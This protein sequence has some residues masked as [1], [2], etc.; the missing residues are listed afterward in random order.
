MK[1]PVDLL[2]NGGIGTYIKANTES[3]SEVNDKTNDAVRVNA[4]ELRCRV[5]AEGGNLGLTQL[6]RIEYAKKGGAINTDAIDN[7]GGVNCSDNE[8][9][10]KILLNKVVESSTITESERNEILANIQNDVA[11]LVLKNNYAQCRAISFASSQAVDSLEMHSRLI[12]EMEESGRLDRTL[13]CLPPQNE[14]D[15]RKSAQQGL[16]R[17]E[18]AVLLA[19]I[20]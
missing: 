14:I 18:I 12:Q 13:E 9:N 10:I 7:S 6:G 11:Q 5:I 16:T 2:W 3:H 20:Y 17:P 15:E 1:A 19:R 4:N 8:V